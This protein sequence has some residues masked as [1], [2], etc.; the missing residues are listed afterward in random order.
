[1]L[2]ERMRLAHKAMNSPARPRI[3]EASNNTKRLVNVND[4]SRQH[5]QERRNSVFGRQA[6]ASQSNLCFPSAGWGNKDQIDELDGLGN[7]ALI[8]IHRLRV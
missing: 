8:K 3:R 6:L 7:L 1:M 5:V 2:L 4:V